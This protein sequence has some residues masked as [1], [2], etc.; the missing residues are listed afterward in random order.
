MREALTGALGSNMTKAF[1]FKAFDLRVQSEGRTNCP[2]SPFHI[3]WH[4]MGVGHGL[5]W[6]YWLFTTQWRMVTYVSGVR[7]L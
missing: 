2:F 7:L 5:R 6:N 1:T 4:I 3:Y